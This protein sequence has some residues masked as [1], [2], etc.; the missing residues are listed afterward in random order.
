MFQISQPR[1]KY[2]SRNLKQHAGAE[3]KKKKKKIML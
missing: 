3:K 1:N 2:D